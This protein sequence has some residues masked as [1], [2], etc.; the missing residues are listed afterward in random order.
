MF[1]LEKRKENTKIITEYGEKLLMGDTNANNIINGFILVL[2]HWL[3]TGIPLIY[4][5]IGKI[6][7]LFYLSALIWA[8]IFIFHFYF[9]GCILTRIER[10]IWNEKKWWGP[11]MFLF[12]PLEKVGV[13]MTDELANMIFNCWGL[14]IIVLIS[15][16]LYK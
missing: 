9:K 3:F 11:W 1:S 16:R 4:L 6:N 14:S 15:I 2:C 13:T 7:I 10:K 5:I 12:T 8:I